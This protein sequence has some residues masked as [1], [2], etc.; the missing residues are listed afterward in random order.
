M[1]GEIATWVGDGLAAVGL[2]LSYASLN[3]S[4]ARLEQIVD[5]RISRVNLFGLEVRDLVR[6]DDDELLDRLAAT[7]TL[8]DLL[9]RIYEELRRSS[10]EEKRRAFA[11]LFASALDDDGATIDNKRLLERALEALEV[12]HTR[13]LKV[14]AAG[15]P[16]RVTVEGHLIAG[17]TS[18]EVLDEQLPAAAGSHRAIAATLE[19]L[20]LVDDVALGTTN[21]FARWSITSFGEELIAY[22][23]DP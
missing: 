13:A 7:P 20:G 11:R 10:V 3:R 8:V 17:G 2:G 6:L 23:V 1:S 15:P 16:A 14:I 12:A 19:G 22:L 21:Y 5:D 9:V 18:L 4:D